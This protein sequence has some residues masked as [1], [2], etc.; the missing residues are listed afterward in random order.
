MA[1]GIVKYA[2]DRSFQL[3]GVIWF[4]GQFVHGQFVAVSCRGPPF[5]YVTNR[6]L[7]VNVPALWAYN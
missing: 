3:I 4:R 1:L 7:Y 6:S 2:Y 5:L